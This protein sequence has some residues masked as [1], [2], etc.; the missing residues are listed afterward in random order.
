MWGT[1][2]ETITNEDT[3]E[4]VGEVVTLACIP[5]LIVILLNA[6]FSF[7]GITAL[8][9]II[10]GAYKMVFSGGDPEKL[11]GARNTIMYAILGLVLVFLSYFIVAFIGETTGVTCIAEFGFDNCK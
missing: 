7:A 1:C 4:I 11:K 8:A 3:G 5:N 10:Y 6:A 9:V 2:I